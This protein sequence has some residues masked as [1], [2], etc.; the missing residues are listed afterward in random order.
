MRFL[1]E[2]G[3]LKGFN[4][5]RSSRLKQKPSGERVKLNS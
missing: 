4:L 2:K 1:Y 5:I 3:L